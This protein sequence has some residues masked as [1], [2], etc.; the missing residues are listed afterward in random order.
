[1]LQRAWQGW[2]VATHMQHKRILAHMHDEAWA[3]QQAEIRDAAI[4]RVVGWLQHGAL[5]RGWHSWVVATHRRTLSR[6]HNDPEATRR[7]ADRAAPMR[8]VICWLQ[9]GMLR[10]A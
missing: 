5:R 3:A 10:R 9:Q 1:M 6:Q 2:V 4:R 7:S 8:R